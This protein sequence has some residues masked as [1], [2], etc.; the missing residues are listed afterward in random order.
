[1]KD[2]TG[3]TLLEMTVAVAILAIATLIVTQISTSLAQANSDSSRKNDYLTMQL[4]VQIALSD[5][6]KCSL[7]LTGMV[8][9]SAN[10]AVGGAGQNVDLNFTP[11][12]FNELGTLTANTDIPTFGVHINQGQLVNAVQ[13]DNPDYANPTDKFYLVRYQLDSGLLRPGGNPVPLAKKQI[14]DFFIQT[15]AANVV[16]QCWNPDSFSFRRR[17]ANAGMIYLPAG[18][19]GYLP[20]QNGC[21][22]LASLNL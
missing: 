10:A 22:S 6:A 5:P 19:R 4:L 21:V 2:Q 8:F 13:M 9:D 7:V 14:S 18:Y 12:G 20:D 17:C 16:Q 1:M 15:N 11:A 3:F